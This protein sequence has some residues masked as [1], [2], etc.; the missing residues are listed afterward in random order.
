MGTLTASSPIFNMH[1]AQHMHVYAR[2][3]ACPMTQMSPSGDW[4]IGEEE[5]YESQPRVRA[6]IVRRYEALYALVEAHIAQA[7]ES[8]RS[9][10]P[11]FLEIGVRVLRE[12][13]ALYRMGSPPKVSEEDADPNAGVDPASLVLASLAEIEGKLRDAAKD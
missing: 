2:V 1:V 13:S 3:H 11:R 10:D 9:G 4:R 7:E 8:G 6:L 5:L 12:M